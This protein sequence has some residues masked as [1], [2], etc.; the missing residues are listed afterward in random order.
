M[1]FRARYKLLQGQIKKQ[2]ESLQL[3]SASQSRAVNHCYKST[4]S[5]IFAQPNECHY[6][7][8]SNMNNNKA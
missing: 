7:H 8:N 3:F 6:L 5:F 2:D 4:Y 1:F